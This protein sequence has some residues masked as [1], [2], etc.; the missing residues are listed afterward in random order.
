MINSTFEYQISYLLILDSLIH[1]YLSS[2]PLHYSILFSFP[3]IPP[4]IIYIFSTLLTLTSYPF[5]FFPS[6]SLFLIF[7]NLLS[8]LIH[9]LLPLLSI[10]FPS[11]SLQSSSIPSTLLFFSLF[12]SFLY[13]PLFFSFPFVLPPSFLFS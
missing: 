7:P 5:H 13:P 9:F 11:L 8:S 6:L 1:S 4:Y 2:S 12:L 10:P 3:S